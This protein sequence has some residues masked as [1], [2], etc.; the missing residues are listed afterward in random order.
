MRRNPGVRAKYRNPAV[1]WFLLDLDRW[2]GR[3]AV[4]D[5][6]AALSGGRE[7]RKQ[8]ESEKPLLYRCRKRG[9]SGAVKIF[10]LTGR[11]R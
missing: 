3:L 1:G 5:A 9:Q 4:L 11:F 10:D 8:A 6:M 7:L 2:A